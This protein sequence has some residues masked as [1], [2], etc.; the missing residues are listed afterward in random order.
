[1]N[2][3]ILTGKTTEHL[4]T[5]EGS[6][7]AIHKLAIL[8]FLRLQKAAKEAGFDLQIASAFRDFD[9]QLKIWNAKAKGER[10]ILDAEEKPLDYTQLSPTEIVYSILRWSAI[11]GCSRHHWGSDID[12]YDGNTQLATEVKLVTSECINSGPSARMHDWLDQRILE[13]SAFGFYRPYGTD[14][15]GVSPERWH[16]SYY[17]VSRRMIQDFSFSLFKKNLEEN[18]IELKE[19]I[20]TN[21]EEIYHR[22]IL[23]FDIP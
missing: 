21:A 23:N 1:M 18:P 6:H 7:W 17:P 3:E 14:R 5:I 4:E 13:N 12:I 11:P 22:F 9:R 2:I 16:I 19:I 20:L 15:G 10:V 8:D